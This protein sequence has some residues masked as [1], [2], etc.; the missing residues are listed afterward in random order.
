MAGGR[1]AGGLVSVPLQR[2]ART[3]SVTVR[4]GMRDAGCKFEEVK[5]KT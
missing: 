3:A 4:C 1:D 2:C 5:R